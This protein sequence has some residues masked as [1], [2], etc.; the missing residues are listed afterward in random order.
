V[1]EVF[2][3]LQAL[4]DNRVGLLALDM[5]NKTDAAGIVFVGRVIQAVSQIVGQTMRLH[6]FTPQNRSG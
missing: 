5:G 4:L 3:D 1:F 2:Q 6:S